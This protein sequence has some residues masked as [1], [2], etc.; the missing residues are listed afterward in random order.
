MPRPDNPFEVA[1]TIINRAAAR[2]MNVCADDLAARSIDECPMETGTLRGTCQYP[3]NDPTG[4]HSATEDDLDA[5]VSYN[6][7]YAAAQ[8]EGAALQ[9]RMHPV[10][11]IGDGQFRTN[12]RVIKPRVIEW[13]VKRYTTPGTKSHFLS[14]PLKAMAPRYER[15]IG[16]QVEKDLSEHFRQTA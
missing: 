5:V 12:T 16:L 6:T 3:S 4:S 14:D 2:A 10:Y 15:L 11:P 13:V 8:H 1:A 7:V 9:H